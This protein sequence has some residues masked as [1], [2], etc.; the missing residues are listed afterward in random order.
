MTGGGSAISGIS[1]LPRRLRDGSGACGVGRKDLRHGAGADA[2]TGEQR[3]GGACHTAENTDAGV[4]G[5][6]RQTDWR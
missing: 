5:V 1:A 2:E 4:S 6:N 3:V